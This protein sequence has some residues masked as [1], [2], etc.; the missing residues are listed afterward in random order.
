MQ[1]EP[2]RH[3][4]GDQ[5]PVIQC[6]QTAPRGGQRGAVQCGGSVDVKVRAR[7]LAK[8]AEHPPLPG[9]QAAVGQVQ[10]RRDGPVLGPHQLHPVCPR[11]QIGSQAGRRP[12]QVVPELAG[13]Y[14]DRQRQ[15]T[16]QPR[17]LPDRRVAL[18]QVRPPGQ[19]GEQPG[20][21]IRRQDVQVDHRRVIQPGQP[22]P[23]GDQHQAPSTARQQRPHLLVPGRVIEHQQRLFARQVIPPARRPRVQARR[24]RRP[25]TPAAT[26][27]PARTSAGSAAGCPGVCAC[28]GTKNCPSANRGASWCAACIDR[29]V[30]PTP[31]IPP[32]A[33][34]CTT[35]GP[36][37]ATRLVNCSSSAARPPNAAMS[38]GSVRI[39]APSGSAN[40]GSPPLPPCSD[41]PRPP[42]A[43]SNTRRREPVRPRPS[44]SDRAV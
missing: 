37:P 16:A 10:R 29:V 9:S 18:I 40:S 30:F 17:E 44:A 43:V 23:A 2:A 14:R 13:H 4:L 26:S 6:M 3:G 21:L 25:R 39:P 5:V 27:S 22:D 15:V 41:G 31:A 34:I 33:Q 11:D 28:S 8:A 36:A 20:G 19:P 38:R 7:L 42:A 35:P 24:D 1:H 32:M 12:R